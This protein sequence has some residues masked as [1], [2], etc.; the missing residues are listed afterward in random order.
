MK[1]ILLQDVK[2]TGTKGQ[3]INASDGHARNFLLPRKLAIE[4]TDANI[5]AR[6]SREK[7]AEHKLQK[8]L[9]AAQAIADRIKE[10]TVR[11]PVRVG[12]NGKMFGSVSNKEIAEALSSQTGIEVDKKKIVLSEPVKSTGRHTAVLKLH[13]QVAAQIAF[14]VVSEH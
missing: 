14:E 11:I 7:Q 9:A 2:G 5:A 4:A 1:V 13:A 8:D 12:E 10:H 3:I 6:E